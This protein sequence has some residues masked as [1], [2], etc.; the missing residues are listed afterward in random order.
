MIYAQ[1]RYPP[2]CPGPPDSMSPDCSATSPSAAS[3]AKGSFWTRSTG[4]RPATNGV[5]GEHLGMSRAGV[6]RSATRAAG[7]RWEEDEVLS[8]R[9]LGPD[10]VS[11]IGSKMS[12]APPGAPPALYGAAWAAIRGPLDHLPP[13]SGNGSPIL[14]PEVPSWR[15]PPKAKSR[16]LRSSVSAW[17][18]CPARRSLSSPRGTPCGW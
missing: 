13:G 6:D 11:V 1:P 12:P 16:S 5:V 15:S 4:R 2:P 8:V 18:F 10:A 17:G 3:R 7:G 9:L 14:L